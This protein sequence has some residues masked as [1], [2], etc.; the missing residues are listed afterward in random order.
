MHVVMEQAP[1]IKAPT[2]GAAAVAE[3]LDFTL[4]VLTMLVYTMAA[5]NEMCLSY[6]IHH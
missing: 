3:F 1:P 4:C 5:I 6:R 2:R